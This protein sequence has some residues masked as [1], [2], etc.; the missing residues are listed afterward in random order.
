M[1]EQQ[2][3]LQSAVQQQQ[4]LNEQLT[5]V[6]TQSAQIRDTMM[7]LQGVIEYLTQLG[8][9]LPEPE[10]V[11]AEFPEVTEQDKEEMLKRK[12]ENKIDRT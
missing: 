1:T 4:A 6:S 8:V 11:A 12:L 3:H 5:Q 9:T 10:Q 7:K 2:Q